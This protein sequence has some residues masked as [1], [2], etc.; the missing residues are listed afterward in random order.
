METV[1]LDPAGKLRAA[2]LSPKEVFVLFRFDDMQSF[3]KLSTV[4]NIRKRRTGTQDF[5]EYY[6]KINRSD[7]GK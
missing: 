6:R 1:P 3:L 4:E 5:S 2:R 7:H